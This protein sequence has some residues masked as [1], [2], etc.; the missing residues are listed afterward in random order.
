MP[1]LGDHPVTTH[2]SWRLA[3]ALL[4]LLAAAPRVGPGQGPSSGLGRRD[5]RELFREAMRHRDLGHWQEASILFEAARRQKGAE[6]ERIRLYGRKRFPHYLPRFYVGEA[7]FHLGD[8]PRAFESWSV[9]D[10]GGRYV[11]V[12][13]EEK[14]D[15]IAHY[16]WLYDK[17]IYPELFR[18]LAQRMLAARG[19]LASLQEARGS[20]DVERWRDLEA[21]VPKAEPP[22]PAGKA[23]ADR[24]QALRSCLDAAE[25]LLAEAGRTRD[26]AR[27]LQASRLLESL[28]LR[29]VDVQG[30]VR[31]SSGAKGPPGAAPAATRAP[32]GELPAFRPPP[33]P[34]SGTSTQF[35]ASRYALVVG[36]WEYK[37]PWKR[38]TFVERDITEVAAVLRKVGYEVEVLPNPTKETLEK[39]LRRFLQGRGNHPNN[40]VL[41][42]YAGHGAR[43]EVVKDGIEN[44][45][46]VPVDAGAG[47]DKEPWYYSAV[48]L[49]TLVN[50]IQAVPA[51]HVLAV[52]DSCFSGDI[53]RYSFR[54]P[55]GRPASA[56]SGVQRGAGE[57][58]WVSS[59]GPG[60]TGNAWVDRELNRPARWYLTAGRADEKV[61][62]RSRFREA[63]VE[64]LSGSAR[65][66]EPGVL[67]VDELTT[68]I[69]R[70][71]AGSDQTPLGEHIGIDSQNEGQILFQVP[72]AMD[73]A[74]WAPSSAALA[75]LE[76]GRPLARW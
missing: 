11:G 29:I 39:T 44:A 74:R 22:C 14:R 20:L 27:T 69:Q 73:R 75:R 36:I 56:G 30:L 63:F 31:R 65:S 3:L 57:V 50:E 25:T 52:L 76:I 10:P 68:F 72:A 23:A 2:R 19:S 60:R 70:R 64:A 55:E 21:R 4:L 26:H 7:L 32:G 54:Q 48:P 13:P 33:S 12:L 24:L 49:L 41:V 35:Y 40:Q 53:F 1:A 38:L 66:Q 6:G 37:D 28:T 47:S 67:T 71:L 18:S 17:G 43:A 62:D 5:Y 58:A 45:F 8:Y 34:P 9:Y 15:S 42:Y 59:S 46:I 16:R 51:E 61:P